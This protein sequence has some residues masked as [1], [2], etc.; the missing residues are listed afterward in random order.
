MKRIILVM[1]MGMIGIFAT[2]GQ[3][4]LNLDT[5]IQQAGKI[6]NDSMVVGAK[7]ALLNCS[8]GSDD[9]SAYVM[10]KMT[11]T[12]DNGRKLTLIT[13][14]DVD[15]G[16]VEMNLRLSSEINDTPALELGKRLGAWVVVTSSFEK[17]GNGYRYTFR[18]LDVTTRTL[19]KSSSFNVKDDQQLRQLLGIK[20]AAAVPATPVPAPAPIPAPIT[21]P[22]STPA[23]VPAPVSAA[24]YKIGDTGPAGG[25]IFYDKGNN[26]NGWRYL[27]AAPVE[28]E[29]RA[30]WSDRDFA[31][32]DD[33]YKTRS[34]IGYGKENTQVI[35]EK[36]RKTTGNWNTAAQKAR[37][38]S[39]NGFN[40]WFL[41][42][43][44]EL[45]QIFGN[46]KRKN[47]GNFKDEMYWS[48]T[49]GKD[50][51]YRE[52]IAFC[53]NFKDGKMGTDNKTS[54]H[55]L[56]RPIRQVAGQ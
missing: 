48:S 2:F 36:F 39:F 40:D 54:N 47:L 56:I 49:E 10:D 22:V 5:A 35:V 53:Q 6:I 50:V 9:L 37:D 23:P 19:L 51:W 38:L 32:D 28:A 45:D 18:A 55:Y 41:P 24:V 27:E 8:S 26:T 52:R 14:K 31:I 7:T 42:S 17:N 30:I 46:L 20:E 3:S 15:E 34:D 29:F 44:T 25:L 4:E 16:R 11:T 43:Q 12:L 13:G 1:L 33:D 21:P